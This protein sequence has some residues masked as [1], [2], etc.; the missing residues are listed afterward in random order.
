MGVGGRNCIVAS[1]G[2]EGGVREGTAVMG[3]ITCASTSHP[4]DISVHYS[5]R[6]LP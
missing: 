2:W 5:I 3:V 4:I 6:L 1:R